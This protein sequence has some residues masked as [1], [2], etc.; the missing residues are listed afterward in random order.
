[1]TKLSRLDKA[2][3]QNLQQ[4]GHFAFAY[5]YIKKKILE[6]TPEYIWFENAAKINAGVGPGTVFARKQTHFGYEIINLPQ[7]DPQ[8][9]SEDIQR[10]V[11]GS[12]LERGDTNIGINQIREHEGKIVVDKHGLPEHL[13]TFASPITSTLLTG[14]PLSTLKPNLSWQE[15]GEMLRTNAKAAGLAGLKLSANLYE[16]L[17]TGESNVSRFETA[18]RINHLN[19]L[20]NIRSDRGSTLATMVGTN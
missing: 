14:N 3:L 7:V 8:I 20:S 1:M 15:T 13:W 9:V 5:E 18:I 12:I 17:L 11:L 19:A 10:A 2:F 16:Q 4:N 6:G